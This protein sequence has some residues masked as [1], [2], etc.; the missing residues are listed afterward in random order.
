MVQMI[1]PNKN[2]ENVPIPPNF[3]GANSLKFGLWLWG[4]LVSEWSNTS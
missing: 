2:S 1:G 4:C 3:A